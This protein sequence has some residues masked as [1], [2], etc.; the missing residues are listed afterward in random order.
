MPFFIDTSALF[1]RYQVEKGSDIVSD[2]LEK[3]DAASSLKLGRDLKSVSSIPFNF[4]IYFSIFLVVV[5]QI[6]GCGVPFHSVSNPFYEAHEI[7]SL[8][9]S[10]QI[11]KTTESDL[12]KLLGKPTYEKTDNLGRKKWLYLSDP[13]REEEIRLD[14]TFGQGFVIDYILHGDGGTSVIK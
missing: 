5:V 4:F 11:N 8:Y 9:N 12:L 14:V 1:K 10:V 7:R 13:F 2:I 3:K 6:C